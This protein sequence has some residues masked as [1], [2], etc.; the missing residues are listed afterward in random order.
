MGNV[1]VA[2]VRNPQPRFQGFFQEKATET[3]LTQTPDGLNF[4]SCFPLF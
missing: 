3:R 2:Y 4:V 1:Q